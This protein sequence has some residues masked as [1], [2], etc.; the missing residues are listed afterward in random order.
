MKRIIIFHITISAIFLA[1][2][3]SCTN[4][5]ISAERYGGHSSLMDIQ[6]FTGSYDSFATRGAVT[7]NSFANGNTYG[8]FFCKHHDASADGT[9]SFETYGS[10]LDNVQAYKASSGWQYYLS[11][12][13]TY[14]NNVYILQNE[15]GDTFDCYAYAPYISSVTTPEAI[16]FILTDQNDIMWAVENQMS[17]TNKDISVDGEPKTI[18]LHFLHALSLLTLKFTLL[19][20]TTSSSSLT[21]VSIK[22]SETAATPF[23]SSG[24]F[25]AITGQFIPSSLQTL[26][27][28]DECPFEYSSSI[29]PTE[30]LTIQILVMPAELQ[31]DDDIEFLFGIDSHDMPVT[32]KIKRND[33]L[34]SD[35]TTYGFQAGFNYTFN[36]VYDNYIRLSEVTIQSDWTDDP[37][38]ERNLTI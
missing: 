34:H 9:D 10:G 17:D 30:T 6:T 35:G 32:Y 33:V 26:G 1:V 8:L 4:D 27:N 18:K 25:N 7:G 23:Y 11:G 28:G 21:K 19:D 37:K 20:N 38:G 14:L 36:F 2:L 3:S 24:T 12:R 13:S 16:P 15:D 5:D 31:A 29:K 22:R